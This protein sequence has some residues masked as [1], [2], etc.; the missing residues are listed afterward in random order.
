MVQE[1][2]QGWTGEFLEGND[3]LTDGVWHHVAVVRDSAENENRLY[4]DGVLNDSVDHHY[5]NGEGFESEQL[6]ST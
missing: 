1:L 3:D 4:V 5:D 2:V 6:T